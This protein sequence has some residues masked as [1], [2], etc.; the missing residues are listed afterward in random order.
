MKDIRAHVSIV[1]SLASCAKEE[2]LPMIMERGG[3][4]FLPFSCSAKAAKILR[5]RR[6]Y[7]CYKCVFSYPSDI[8]YTER[9]LKMRIL[10][11]FTRAQVF[12]PWLMQGR[13]RMDR[14]FFCAQWRLLGW[15]ENTLFLVRLGSSSIKLE[16]RIEFI[17][18]VAV[19]C[20]SFFSQFHT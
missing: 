4:Y 12:C 13:T 2:T 3:K 10:I 17:Y 6:S 1:S 19:Y 8:R 11:S 18:I 15:M 14:S 20:K 7:G 9:D 16:K 5:C